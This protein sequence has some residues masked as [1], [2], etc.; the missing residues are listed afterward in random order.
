VD[1]LVTL[2][3]GTL[4]CGTLHCG[5]LHSGPCSHARAHH[6]A[7][8]HL[9]SQVGLHPGPGNGSRTGRW[10]H[11]SLTGVGSDGSAGGGNIRH[12]GVT[13]RATVPH[14]PRRSAIRHLGSRWH[15]EGRCSVRRMRWSASLCAGHVVSTDVACYRHSAVAQSCSTSAFLPFAPS[16]ERKR[17]SKTEPPRPPLPFSRVGV[18]SHCEP[19]KS[20]LP[21]E[22][23][24]EI[25]PLTVNPPHTIRPRRHKPLLCERSH[26]VFLLR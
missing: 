8:L 7:P 18:W 6:G 4:H 13:T 2:H 16:C 15:S 12:A 21:D 17:V 3:C 14:R 19:S 10:D 5:T 9:P 26:D 1:G 11:P 23:R 25:A 22:S 24:I 20:A